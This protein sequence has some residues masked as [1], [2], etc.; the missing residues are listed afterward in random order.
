MSA[1]L[2]T[3]DVLRL[4]AATGDFPPLVSP[5]ATAERR[6]TTCGSRVTVGLTFDADGRVDT[7]GH[8]VNACALG[9][10]AATI[11]GR[12][13]AGRHGAALVAAR[14]AFALWLIEPDAPAPDWP[15]IEVLAPARAYPARHG[16][17]RLPFEAAADAAAKVTA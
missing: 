14:D 1:P 10:A 3:L 2:Y 13:V 8:S 6:A 4:A 11:F 15:G 9:Q 16:A 12:G 17:M 5:D 7:Y